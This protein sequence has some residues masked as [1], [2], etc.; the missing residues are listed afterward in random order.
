MKTQQG[1]PDCVI[2]NNSDN[3]IFFGKIG[4]KNS[5]VTNSS[6]GGTITRWLKR[7]ALAQ[8]GRQSAVKNK[9]AKQEL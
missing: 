9:I 4:F 5:Q 6:K 3:K 7:R 1:S 8:R 2:L